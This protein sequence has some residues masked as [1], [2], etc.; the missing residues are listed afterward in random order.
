M[1]NIFDFRGIRIGIMPA[2]C[3]SNPAV[4]TAW[5]RFFPTVTSL[6]L[7]ESPPPVATNASL[8]HATLMES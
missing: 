2:G 3:E 8:S 7:M 4:R 5:Q 6:S 1:T